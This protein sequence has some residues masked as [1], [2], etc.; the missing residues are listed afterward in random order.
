[1]FMTRYGLQ[2]LFGAVA[3]GAIILAGGMSGGAVA[4]TMFRPVAVVNDAAVTGYDLDQRAKILAALGFRGGDGVALK[5]EA[6]DRLI[7]DR[8]KVQAGASGGITAS[9]EEIDDALGQ[10]AKRA[11]VTPEQLVAGMGAKGVTEQALRDMIAADVVWRGVVRARFSRRTEPAEGEIDAEISEMTGR[12]GRSYKLA[13]IGLPASGGGR[14]AADTAALADRLY[15]E[16]NSGADFDAAVKKYSRAPSAKRGGELGWVPGNQL[17]PDLVASLAALK[18][19]EVAPPLP[20]TGGVSILK[21]LDV[22]SDDSD[23]VD[24][25]DPQLR[26][27]ARVKLQNERIERLAEGLLQ[28]LRRDAL[29]ELRGQ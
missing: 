16:L 12:I 11:K 18:P 25:N 7:D 29:I 23:A 14:S 27:R 13:E 28:E 26:D 3:L 2:T 6:L 21:L 15:A 1:M 20:V 8:L 9:P 4:Q 24:T 19:G 22:R 10:I 17:P 5:R